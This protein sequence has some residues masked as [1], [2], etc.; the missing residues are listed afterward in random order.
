MQLVLRKYDYFGTCKRRFMQ[1]LKELAYIIGSH[2]LRTIDIIDD[3]EEPKTKT[4]QF[5]DKII[6]GDFETDDEAA[7]Y[8]YQKDKTYS[9]Y[10]KLKANLKSKMI[11]TLFF[12]DMK[13]SSYFERQKA[14]NI[15]HREWVAAKILIAKNARNAGVNLCHKLLKSSKKYEITE[16]VLDISRT[17]R[18]HYG[19][20]L[21]NQKKF[22]YYNQIFKEFEPLWLKENLAE[23]YYIELI[24][25]YVN[26]KG[27]KEELHE[28][29]KDYYDEIEDAMLI[30]DSYKLH[31]CGRMIKVLIYTS[32][33]D[34]LKTVEVCEKAIGFFQKKKY[35]ATTPLQIF[36]YQL[37]VEYTQLKKYK[38]GEEAAKTCLSLMEEG[39][40]NWFKYRE[41][42]FILCLHTERY[43]KAYEIFRATVNHSRF[44]FLPKNLKELWR[45]FEAYLHYLVE[46]KKIKVDEGNSSFNKFRLGRFLND[47]PIYSKDKRGLN[48]PILVIHILF[49]IHQRKYGEAI[50]RIERIEKYCT[51][52]LRKNDTYRSNCFIRMLMRIPGSSFHK[53]GVIRKSTPYLKKLSE[54]PLDVA[55][56]THEIEIIPYENLWDMTIQTLDNKFHYIRKRKPKTVTNN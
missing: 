8:F 51:R 12:I 47:M 4:R 9:G 49:M 33:N 11:N 2:K 22:D 7:Q 3:T 10:Q 24:T 17:L 55:N 1:V 31:L 29:A 35:K 46:L 27:T 20:R 34:S 42:Y 56:Q 30:Y 37:L 39:T 26:S 43:Q 45:I 48:I 44:Q 38:E 19:G 50:D 28:K 40:Y 5:Y 41:L 16:L 14:Y 18:L 32:I 13:E 25:K 52:H 15:C 53:A 6:E 54:T 23:E 36:Y 21:G